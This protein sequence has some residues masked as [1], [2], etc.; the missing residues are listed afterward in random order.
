[1]VKGRTVRCVSPGN[2]QGFCSFPGAVRTYEA[3]RAKVALF[4]G[5]DALP[6][7]PTRLLAEVGRSACAQED[8]PLPASRD[9]G[10]TLRGGQ[11]NN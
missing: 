3:V 2:A 1:M 11:G 4:T 6:V 5:V 7:L 8:A 10:V 9:R